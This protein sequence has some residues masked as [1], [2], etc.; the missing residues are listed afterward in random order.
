MY[1]IDCMTRKINVNFYHYIRENHRKMNLNEELVDF[2]RNNIRYTSR[3]K[4]VEIDK[5]YPYFKDIYDQYLKSERFKKLILNIKLKYDDEYLK[6]F[7]RHSRN[8]LNFYLKDNKSNKD[9]DNKEDENSSQ[10]DENM[11]ENAF[12]G[13][14]IDS[15]ESFE[16]HLDD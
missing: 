15:D 3:N 8:F 9:Y 1:R 2:F 6:L 13:D 7:F 12:N 5:K 16:N 14:I 4:F 10:K 11:S